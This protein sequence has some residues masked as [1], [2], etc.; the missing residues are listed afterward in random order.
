MLVFSHHLFMDMPNP[1]WLEMV[2]QTASFGI[3]FPSGLTIMTVLMYIFR[4][5]I[6]WNI[7]ALFM[8]A[9]IAGWAFG[10]FAGVETGW[11]GT[12]LYL[13]NTLNVVGH[14]HFVLL[15]GS[16]LFGIGLIYSI[17]PAITKKNLE[18]NLGIVHLV[19]T[20]IGGFGLAFMFLFLGFAG[21]VRREADIPQIFAWALPWLLFLALVVGFGQIVFIYNLFKTLLRKKRSN[22]EKEYFDNQ[23]IRILKEKENISV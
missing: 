23:Q 13:H 15:M 12:D 6:K 7:T 10:G 20:L 17:V 8:M 2:A 5:R 3:V 14:I 22:Q 1:D 9:G 11:R 18:V 4:S 16:V 19:S 21:F